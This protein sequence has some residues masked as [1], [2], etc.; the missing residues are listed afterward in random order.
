MKSDKKSPETSEKRKRRSALTPEARDN[1]LI[2]LAYDVAEKQMLDGSASSQVISHFLKLG[3][4]R[5]RLEVEK[6]RQETELIKAKQVAVQRS[7]GLE[8]LYTKAMEA[9]KKYSGSV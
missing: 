3:S 4:E 7:E 1:Q 6:I 8:E 2:S 5:T 9:M